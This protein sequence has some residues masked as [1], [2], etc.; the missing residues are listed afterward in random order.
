MIFVGDSDQDLAGG[1]AAGVFTVFIDNGRTIAS[2]LARQPMA[3]A[4]NPPGAYAFV[5]K[6]VIRKR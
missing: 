2:E 5:R 4:P 3:V 6:Q 1:G